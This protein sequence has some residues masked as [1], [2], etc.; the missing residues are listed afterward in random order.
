[1]GERGFIEG[2][3]AENF[4]KRNG[5]L[6]PQNTSA[7]VGKAQILYNLSVNK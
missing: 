7:R 5:K 4:R 2:G 6:N 3:F 1:L